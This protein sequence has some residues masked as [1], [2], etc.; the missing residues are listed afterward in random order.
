[1]KITVNATGPF[2]FEFSN[3]T[4]S[5]S[6][7]LGFNNEDTSISS[8][9]T[10]VNV[11]NLSIPLYIN[12]YISEF[13]GS[14]KSSNNYDNPTFV[15]TTNCNNS[16]ILTFTAHSYYNQKIEVTDNNIQTL[17]VQLRDYNNTL[18]DLN[19]ANW[20]LILQ[21]NYDCCC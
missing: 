8:T 6:Y 4:D 16:E 13:G 14:Y 11:P 19:G 7:L 20:M 9:Q 21:L 10:S 18:L 12:I 15:C 5:A 17:H 2:N 1:M 3:T